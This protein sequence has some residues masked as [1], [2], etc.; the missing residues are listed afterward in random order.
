VGYDANGN[1]ISAGSYDYENRLVIAGGD[2][3]S[4]GPDNLRVWKI[5][6]DGSQDVYFYDPAGRKIAVYQV[7]MPGNIQQYCI[8]GSIT[9]E[10]FAGEIL[11]TD[12]LGSTTPTFPYGEP[13]QAPL[14]DGDYYATYYWGG[15][16][17][18]DYAQNRYYSSILGRFLSAD[19]YMANTGGAG[20][21]ADPG[22]W[23]R[24]AYVEDDPVNYNDPMGLYLQFPVGGGGG[25]GWDYGGSGASNGVLS[26]GGG[27]SGDGVGVDPAWL[28]MVI[29][30]METGGSAPSGGPQQ[31]TQP[32]QPC[33]ANLPNI[34]QTLAELAA[35]IEE[36]AATEISGFPL[37]SV[38]SLVNTDATQEFFQISAMV[39]AG[40]PYGPDYVGGHFNL[41]LPTQALQNALGSDFGIFNSLFGGTHDGTRQD[42][43][44]GN[45]AQGNFTL[46]SKDQTRQYGSFTFHFDLY[47]GMN[48]PIGTIQHFYGDVFVGHLGTP[49]LD[50]AWAK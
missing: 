8:C 32:N 41:V 33:W 14:S 50:P 3:Y 7:S 49:C 46:H 27:G 34:G 31:N 45:A 38:D 1:D 23:N 13:Y 42:A 24:Y 16:T 9:T 29:I 26:G 2:A 36:I 21:P 5:R 39:A 35:N 25:L 22:S 47:N 48:L 20:N 17:G 40:K 18:L 15:S 10:W 37:A 4:Y 12:R 30:F 43:V 44:Y 28:T 6:S 11:N 19:P